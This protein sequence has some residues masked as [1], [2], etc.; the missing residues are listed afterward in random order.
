[1]KM[2]SLVGVV[3]AGIAPVS[4]P[5]LHSRCLRTVLTHQSGTAGYGAGP[6]GRAR[7]GSLGRRDSLSCSSSST[8]HNERYGPR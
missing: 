2:G 1:M 4:G 3:H 5:A 6:S 8:P 7:F